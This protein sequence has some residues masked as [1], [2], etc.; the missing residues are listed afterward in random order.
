M[1]LL[2]DDK[3]LFPELERYL[4]DSMPQ[5]A[6]ISVI[7]NNLVAYGGFKTVAHARHALKWGTNPFVVPR[8]LSNEFCANRFGHA[9][10]A[11]ESGTPNFIEIAA[12]DMDNF[13]DGVGT[14]F[15][16]DGRAVPIVGVALLHALCHWGNFDNGVTE[17]SE[18]GFDFERATYGRVIG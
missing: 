6:N 17:A 10:C 4:R 7:V 15:T 5:C 13:T 8:P 11:F 9:K 3:I 1:R 12:S 14:G 2:A 16:A 18:R